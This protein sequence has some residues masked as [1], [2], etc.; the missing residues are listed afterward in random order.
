MRRL[1]LRLTCSLL[2]TATVVH[3]DEP[4]AP[5]SAPAV[6]PDSAP[7]PGFVAGRS[8]SLRPADSP[9]I[10]SVDHGAAW[11]AR[12][13]RGLTPPYPSSFRF[14]EDQGNWYTPFDHPGMPG[15]YDL[16]GWH[17]P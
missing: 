14:L 13:L 10:T 8:P 1:S 5:T 4:A 11:Y 3:A 15:P 17:R 2:I 9:K 7:P 12:A 6:A 16:R